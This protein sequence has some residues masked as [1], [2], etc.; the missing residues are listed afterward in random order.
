MVAISADHGQQPLPELVGGWRINNVELER[1]IE[2][3]F[4]PI[5]EKITPVDIYLD[6]DRVSSDDID[7]TDIARW[8]S[9]YTLA[10]NIPEQATGSD[11]VP[12]A[13]LDDRL[14]AGVFTTEFL[15]SLTQADFESYGSGD[16][17]EGD[18]TVAPGD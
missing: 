9:V 16:Y 1:D 14:F 13:R 18:F 8:L 5:V 10:D 2:D 4:G 12:D 15:S 17:P 6:R 3:E 11:R 7:P